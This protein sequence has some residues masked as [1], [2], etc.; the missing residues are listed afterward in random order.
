VEVMERSKTTRS[1]N[2]PRSHATATTTQLV[3]E[4][5]SKVY[6]TLK[7]ITAHRQ[8]TMGCCAYQQD[9][10]GTIHLCIEPGLLSPSYALRLGLSNMYMFLEDFRC[11][12]TFNG[13]NLHIF[14]KSRQNAA[15]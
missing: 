8:R 12:N 14:S 7:A 5:Q 1:G 2:R 9:T 3:P 15:A 13:V 11:C 6:L 10:G 4:N